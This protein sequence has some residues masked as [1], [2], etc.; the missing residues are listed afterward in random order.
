MEWR[1]A[2][3][4]SGFLYPGRLLRRCGEKYTHPLSSRSLRLRESSF[5]G[6]TFKAIPFT[7]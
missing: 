4:R 5:W 6:I 1:V 3:H 2:P 7:I